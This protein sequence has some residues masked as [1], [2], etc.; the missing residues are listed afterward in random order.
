M[1][2][3]TEHVMMF[4]IIIICSLFLH[5]IIINSYSNIFSSIS[6]QYGSDLLN[7]GLAPIMVLVPVFPNFHAKRETFNHFQPQ[8]ERAT[9]WKFFF[10]SNILR[11][12]Y[13]TLVSQNHGYKN[14]K[15]ERIPL[16][17][18]THIKKIAVCTYELASNFS[19]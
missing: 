16:K 6:S 12:F 7:V 3:Y 17:P 9:G 15:M 11:R 19:K 5:I 10:S 8:V 4:D 18:K 14:K 2:I 13:A 1:T